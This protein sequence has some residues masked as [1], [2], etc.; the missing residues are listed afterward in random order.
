M[1][2][3][4]IERKLFGI[5]SAAAIA[6]AVV[7]TSEQAYAQ[8]PAAE[9]NAVSVT[10]KGIVGGGLL[11]GEVVI[12]TMGIIGVED[13]WPYLVFGGLGAVGGAIGGYFI[14][15]A[16]DPTAE[17]PLYLLAGGMALVI[18]TVVV[19]LNATAYKPPR[20]DRTEPLTEK[21]AIEPA[22]PDGTTVTKPGTSKVTPARRTK[23]RAKAPDPIP[24]VPLAMI[25]LTGEDLAFGL[26][27]PLVRPMYTRR[28][29]AEYGV[30]QGT[31]VRVPVFSAAF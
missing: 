1:S 18:P 7:G 13:G 6:A 17:V 31:E 8:T 19:A 16:A 15:S 27:A 23:A 26:P 24:R 28:E 2:L 14:E 3:G 12:I 5:A 22:A 9:D 10:G 25:S 29:L 21:P 20:D 4:R 11:G 30:T